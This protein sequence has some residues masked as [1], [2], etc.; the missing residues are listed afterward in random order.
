[1]KTLSICGAERCE[2]VR[3]GCVSGCANTQKINEMKD[4]SW[5]AV[6]GASSCFA[7]ASFDT[8]SLNDYEI[9]TKIDSGDFVNDYLREVTV[10]LQYL[11]LA[12]PSSY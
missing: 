4:A 11:V 6:E 7:P 5:Y 3:S 8:A 10:F 1:M 9:N 2:F 12:S